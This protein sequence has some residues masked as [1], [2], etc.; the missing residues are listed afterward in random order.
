MP[1]IKMKDSKGISWP[2]P[3]TTA[4]GDRHLLELRATA[5][6]ATLWQTRPRIPSGPSMSAGRPAVAAPWRRSI[7]G[8]R[9]EDGREILSFF[10]NADA[11][12][13]LGPPAG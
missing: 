13:V 12:W 9:M 1:P 3:R 2:T 4:A 5:R 11:G 6:T 8:N 10:P 7:R